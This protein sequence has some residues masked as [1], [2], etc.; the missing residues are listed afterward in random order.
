[1]LF[2]KLKNLTG[3][4]FFL[5][6]KDVASFGLATEVHG[7]TLEGCSFVRAGGQDYQLDKESTKKVKKAI[8][9]Y[10]SSSYDDVTDET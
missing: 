8:L 4:E 6:L 3:V 1:M 5:N 9:Q 7:A 2:L 10:S